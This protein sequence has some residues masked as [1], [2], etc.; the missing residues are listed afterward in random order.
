[1][2]PEVLTYIETVA[3]IPS[4]DMIHYDHVGILIYFNSSLLFRG[5][6][7]DITSAAS[8][9]LLLSYPTRVTKDIDKLT[10]LFTHYK[11]M[12]KV[13]KVEQQ[14]KTYGTTT[15][16]IQQYENLSKT[17]KNLQLH[18]EK[19][20]DKGAHG[21]PY[22]HKLMVAGKRLS[23][24]CRIRRLQKLDRTIPKGLLSLIPWE[25]NKHPSFKEIY[26]MIKEGKVTPRAL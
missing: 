17:I 6:S 23:L 14:F 1:M 13:Q 3:L 12:T 25:E 10:H 22:S 24:L 8:R 15:D 4:G 11:I 2:T 9:K 21:Y 18:A 26:T 19:E 5:I 20:C 7:K 16:T